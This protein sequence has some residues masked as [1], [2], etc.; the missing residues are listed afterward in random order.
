M[1]EQ[2]AAAAQK[3]ELAQTH[4]QMA[5]EGLVNTIAQRLAPV[6]SP[7]LERLANWI[8][9]NREMIGQRVEE[10]VTKLAGAVD[11]F[12]SGGGLQKLGD[13]ILGI[14]RGVESLRR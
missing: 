11:R 12:V 5:G 13:Q 6:I 2:G 10:I 7:L 1:T 14:C 8:A 3:F 9:A 4:L